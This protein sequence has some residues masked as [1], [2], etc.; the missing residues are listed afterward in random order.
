MHPEVYIIQN[1]S[2]FGLQSAKIIS[3]I[4]QNQKN[5]FNVI[6][7]SGGT[8][9]WPVYKELIPLLDKNSNLS[10][11]LF[12]Q[13]DERIVASNSE[14]SNQ[15]AV[16]EA[17]FN[18][19]FSK[20]PVF[21]PAPVETNEVC[22]NYAS[23]IAQVMPEGK[24]PAT[25]SAAILG[26]GPDGHIASLFPEDDWENKESP[27]DFIIVKPVSQPE[28]RLSL[29]FSALC[30]A[31]NIIFLVSGAAKKD[32]LE[33]VIINRNSRLPAAKLIRSRQTIISVTADA[34]SQKLADY[35]AEKNQLFRG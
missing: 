33:E 23:L 28:A 5:R 8:T 7:L 24:W 4:I 35:L 1:S 3:S 20:K 32:I 22:N 9:P 26:I 14:R 30:R 11:F 34:V 13:T 12:I 18:S 19:S 15:K 27:T 29:T 31:Q 10:Q 25:I 6:S 17:I 2:D 21:V 16:K